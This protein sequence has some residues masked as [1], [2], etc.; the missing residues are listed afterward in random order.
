MIFSAILTGSRLAG[1]AQ[2]TRRKPA[3]TVSR[4]EKTAAKAILWRWLRTAHVWTVRR[5]SVCTMKAVN[6]MQ[7]RSV[8]KAEMR[9]TAAVQNA[10]HSSAAVNRAAETPE[11]GVLGKI[12]A[13]AR[14]FRAL[15][16]GISL[17]DSGAGIAL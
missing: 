14:I 9:K 11:T 1:K 10:P 15:P 17:I 8:W 16:Q 5:Q 6:V 2:R 13:S 12:R 4:K 7:A 3:A